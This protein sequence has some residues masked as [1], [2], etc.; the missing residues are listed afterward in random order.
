MGGLTQTDLRAAFGLAE[1]LAASVTL[2]GYAELVLGALPALIACDVCTYNEVNPGRRRI[3]WMVE[4]R[5]VDFADSAAIFGQHMH[6]H[7]HLAYWSHATGAA[8][9]RVMTRSDFI[10]DPAWSDTGLARDFYARVGAPHFM[11]LRLP[12]PGPAEVHVALLRDRDFADRERALLELL[13]PALANA[14]EAALALDGR[15]RELARLR[16]GLAAEGASLIALGADLAVR[17]MGAEAA[18]AF[19]AFVDPG[20]RPG[21]G[22]PRAIEG[23]LRA[24]L[25]PASGSGARPAARRHFS[26]VRGGRALTVRLLDEP[27]GYLLLLRE[28]RLAIEPGDL[29]A[30]GLPRRDAEVLAWLA[31]GHSNA[32]IADRLGVRPTTVKHA[33]ER[34]YARLGVTTRAA[35]TALAVRAAGGF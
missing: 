23:W 8:Q 13:R 16:R 3:A 6:E 1:R 11:G 32:A 18:D 22:L 28:R 17:W 24:Q 33:L 15:E 34:I 14:Y 25:S 5:T 31:Q 19:A 20:W 7:P 2:D 27:G 35:A 30:L 29:A 26:A 4:P 12:T 21:N 9:A 10:A